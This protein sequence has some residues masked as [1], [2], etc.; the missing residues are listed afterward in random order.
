MRTLLGVLCLSF[1]AMICLPA[2]ATTWYVRPDGGTRY[3]TNAKQG[4][5]DGKGDAPYPGKGTN[6]HCAFNDVRLLW[7]DGSYAYNTSP[8]PAWGWVIQGGDTVILR[9]SIAKGVSYRIG[10]NAALGSCTDPSVPAGQP[11]I[12]GACGNQFQGAP[13]PPSGTVEH[14]TRIL[15]ENYQSCSAQSA[16]TQ[17]H[18]GWGVGA[19]LD[20]SG[21]SYIDLECLDITD[22]SSCGRASQRSACQSGNGTVISDYAG[23]GISLNNQSTHITLNNL[24]IHGLASFGLYGA[25]G[26]GSVFTN[27][28]VLGNAGGGW[29]ADRGDG[30][31]GLGTLL[32]QH[33]SIE[34]NGCAEEYPIVDKVPYGDCT[35][36]NSGGYGDGFGTATVTSDAPGWQVHFDQGT[37]AYNTQ[38]GLDALHL[39][40]NGSS[41]TVTRTLAYGNMGQQL[42]VGGQSGT[43]INNLVVGNCFAMKEAIPGTPAGFNAKLSDYCRAGDVAVAATVANQSKLTLDFNTIYSANT[44]GV[45]VECDAY[46]GQCS[47]SSLID[48]RN[49]I[50]VG[51]VDDAAHGNPKG[52]GERPTPVY[53]GD[54]LHGVNPFANQG[55][56][57]SN[58]AVFHP[59][60][61][62]KCPTS[63]ETHALCGDPGLKDERW[64]LYG[65]GDM[66]PA[67][68]SSAVVGSGVAINGVTVDFNGA[69]RPATPSRGALEFGDAPSAASVPTSEGTAVVEGESQA[70]DVAGASDA[71]KSSEVSTKRTVLTCAGATVL[72]LAGWRVVRYFRGRPS[73]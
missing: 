65:Y 2:C 9:G 68:R 57:F 40:G 54:T 13:P 21:S 66:A 61:N 38:D 37:V 48:Y 28:D 47:S 15:G 53:L 64:H 5:C 73:A 39:V 11:N 14:P 70:A 55:S 3:S 29:N 18:G 31:T 69:T 71:P 50:F 12:R 26:N 20:L 43:L 10:N 32:V 62:W 23:S 36:D 25:T 52:Q 7:Q 17:L 58:N 8:F 60:G 19:V 44:I 24:R 56:V 51:F 41:M 27:I 34:W 45:E 30:K 4:Q 22:F 16:R 63:H 33:Y 42:K 49:N 72:L 67:S 6:R 35:D 59:R 1:M 46:A